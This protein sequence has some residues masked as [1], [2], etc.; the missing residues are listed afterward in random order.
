MTNKNYTN[1]R[2]FDL[3]SLWLNKESLKVYHKY[4]IILSEQEVWKS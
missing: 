2:R 4:I 1:L 3:F